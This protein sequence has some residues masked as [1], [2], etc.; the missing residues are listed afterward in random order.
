MGVIDPTRE[1]IGEL[2]RAPGEGPVVM[3]NLL[4]FRTPDGAKSY[5]RYGR[6]AQPYLERAGA[7]LLY[8]GAGRHL[9]IGEGQRPWWDAIVVVEYPSVDAFL[10]M[11]K[12]PGY[13]DAHVHRAEALERAEL[14]ATAPGALGL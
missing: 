1:Q 3:I 2:A 13:Q 12:D 10:T 4:A 9:V 8:G 14:I 11:I 7:K 5:E 6:E